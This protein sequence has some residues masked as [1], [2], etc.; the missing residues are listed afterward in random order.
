MEIVT[1]EFSFA[2][3]QP[4]TV[5]K[6][7]LALL[8][9]DTQQNKVATPR[10]AYLLEA[11]SVLIID[12][13]RMLTTAIAQALYGAGYRS[14][15]VETEL[16]A[17]TLFLKGVY[18]PQAVLLGHKHKIN[19]LFLQRLLHQSAQ[20][21]GRKV[22][23][24]RL[25]MT[26][27]TSATPS[28]S[29]LPRIPSQPL[30]PAPLHQPGAQMSG[31]EQLEREKMSLEGLDIGR[32]HLEALVGGG[33]Q[34]NVYRVYDRL[35][36]REM[37]LKA[38]HVNSLPYAIARV[39]EEEANLFQQEIDLL[40]TL[41]H[42]HIQAPLNAA[43]SYISGSPFIYKTMPFYPERSLAQW[44]TPQRR[45]KEVLP[46]DVIPVALQL[47]DA[48]HYLHEHQ[49][50]HQNFKLTNLLIREAGKD[51]HQLHLL[52]TDFAI[53]Q[54][55]SFFS[56]THEAYPYMAPERWH[57]QA[58][59]ASDQYGLAAIIYELLT[60]RPPFQGVSEYALKFL[61]INMQPQPPSTFNPA[62]TP[63]IDHVVLR[64]LAKR[65]DDRFPTVEAFAQTL[66]RYC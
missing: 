3:D 31:I 20:K 51:L 34:G 28:T 10:S 61:H 1:H 59:P 38:V 41:D 47:A 23:V 2:V 7:L 54:D 36:E 24:I 56:R 45:Q 4:E 52:F 32:Y 13:D 60:G 12:V 22:P 65:P 29:A 18:I 30:L 16:E 8:Q 53:T 49:I 33:L 14:L 40:S 63:A 42:A 27:S 57:G 39:S 19:Q 26:E 5:L 44:L 37:A 58:L 17:F 48:L 46:R 62:L 9:S 55:G 6:A 21:Y 50:L 25:H 11:Q 64:A 66:Q 35:R 43:R 15:A